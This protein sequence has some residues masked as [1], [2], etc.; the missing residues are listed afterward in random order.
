MELQLGDNYRLTCDKYQYIIQKKS[1]STKEGVDVRWKGEG[2]FGDIES[3]LRYMIDNK[4]KENI[5]SVEAIIEAVN[6]LESKF[7]DLLKAKRG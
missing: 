3:V 2:F 6:N 5:S 4:I 7:Q 1:I